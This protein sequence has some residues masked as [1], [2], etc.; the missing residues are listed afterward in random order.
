M[1][2]AGI[3]VLTCLAGRAGVSAWDWVDIHSEEA[4]AE[5]K[6][7]IASAGPLFFFFSAQT[8]TLLH[9]SRVCLNKWAETRRI[10]LALSQTP[11]LHPC[12]VSRTEYVSFYA[13]PRASSSREGPLPSTSQPVGGCGRRDAGHSCRTL[14]SLCVGEEGVVAD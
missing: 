3:S 12:R 7:V 13:V 2:A 9:F 5:P 6:P 1:K 11:S 14:W 10:A 4:S 8:T